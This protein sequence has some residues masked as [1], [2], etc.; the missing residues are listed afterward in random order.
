MDTKPPQI[1]NLIIPEI[2]PE[3]V[4]TQRANL[5]PPP[6]PSSTGGATPIGV[7]AAPAIP[8]A[9]PLAPAIP[10]APAAPA[11][12]APPA[13]PGIP[14][15]PNIGNPPAINISLNTETP[16]QTAFKQIK[17]PH[18]LKSVTYT[19]TQGI[20]ANFTMFKTM[21][22]DI[23][24]KECLEDF[25][26]QY[27]DENK[28]VEK[29]STD[30]K[31]EETK[32]KATAVLNDGMTLKENEMF[33]QGLMA[34]LRI[35]KT[36]DLKQ[37]FLN[38]LYSAVEEL[39]I[40]VFERFE[41]IDKF[42]SILPQPSNE[43]EKKK[44][45]GLIEKKKENEKFSF[46]KVSGDYSQHLSKP[47]EEQPE[48][49]MID[50][51][52]CRLVAMDNIF[53]RFEVMKAMMKF[54][55]LHIEIQKKLS[56]LLQLAEKISRSKKLYEILNIIFVALNYVSKS[57]KKKAVEA[58]D[59]KSLIELTYDYNSKS[60]RHLKLTKIIMEYAEKNKPYLMNWYDDFP[61]LF[62]KQQII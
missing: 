44:E 17:P 15:A 20:S 30:E 50:E 29:E 34:L 14:A 51:F 37:R 24:I 31:K 8:G 36:N 5:M 61:E 38:F 18:Q 54:T 12:P 11:A 48:L 3:F 42:E 39:D 43:G 47:V 57:Q 27:K 1:E 35:S 4:V 7:P 45:E 33:I 10:S 21:K 26:E 62:I 55:E 59:M 58:F 41:Q 46:E 16:L 6:P 13:A 23:D 40:D 32:K 52:I 49:G 56:E 53:D 2:P 19:Q 9:P 22:I 25:C 60:E 28:K